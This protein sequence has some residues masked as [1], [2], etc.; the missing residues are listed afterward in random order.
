[1]K[2]KWTFLSNH[3]LVLLW[4]A[5]EPDL[6]VSDLAKEVGISERAT[7]G[8]LRDLCE[9]GYLTRSRDGRRARYRINTGAP[10]RTTILERRRLAELLALVEDDNPR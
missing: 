2:K 5:R 1:V 8:I 7:Y 9:T 3:A 10:M 4:L 6:R